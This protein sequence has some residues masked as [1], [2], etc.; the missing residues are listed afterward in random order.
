[1]NFEVAKKI[2]QEARSVLLISHQNPDGDTLGSA[3]TMAHFLSQRDKNC[4]H[5]CAT[6]AAQNYGFLPG[7]QH[8]THDDQVFAQH[9]DVMMIFD[10]GD[11]AYAGIKEL[12]PRLQDKP[13]I[14][15]IDH[16]VTNTFFGDINLVDVSASSTA[17]IVYDLLSNFEYTLTPDIATNLLMGI[18]TDTGHLSNLAT[19]E[20]SLHISAKLLNS[21]AN[22]RSIS[23]YLHTKSL[24]LLRL[25]GRILA[26][27]H[28]NHEFNIACT[29]ITHEDLKEF[30]VEENEALKVTNFLNIMSN[31][32]AVLFLYEKEGGIIKGSFRTTHPLIDVAK[33]AKLLGGG[34]HTKAAGFLLPGRIQMKESLEIV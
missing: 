32:H 9:Y 15:N 31:V 16:H 23:T 33:I 18:M 28:Q 4:T 25:W 29:F 3:L 14:I 10:S 6:P 19:T 34:G 17:E 21:G 11:L 24:Q 5:Y 2:L 8:M 1:M 27:L 12:M 22:Y 30:R 26:R 7:Y 20:K 13:K